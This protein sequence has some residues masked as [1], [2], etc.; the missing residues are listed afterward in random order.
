VG[1]IA[2]PEQFDAILGQRLVERGLLTPDQLRSVQERQNAGNAVLGD[3]LTSTGVLSREDLYAVFAEIHQLRFMELT[4]ENAEQING[5]LMVGLDPAPAAFKFVVC[6][7][8]ARHEHYDTF[9]DAEVAALRAKD[10]RQ[11]DH[12]RRLGARSDAATGLAL[13]GAGQVLLCCW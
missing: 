12:H 13:H 7:A 2:T 9:T 6:M 8:G 5:K 3:V 10:T 11:S 4:G 1:D